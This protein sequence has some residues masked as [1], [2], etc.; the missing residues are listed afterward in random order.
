MSARWTRRIATIGLA[1][2]LLLT[3]AA[4]ARATEAPVDPVP[5]GGLLSDLLDP[6]GGLDLD[7]PGAGPADVVPSGGPATPDTPRT[8]DHRERPDETRATPT[9][10]NSGPA[11]GATSSA[12][13]RPASSQVATVLGRVPR[14]GGPDLPLGNIAGLGDLAP[15]DLLGG[16]LQPD[17]ATSAPADVLPG[18]RTLP[19]P[20]AAGDAAANGLPAGGTAVPVTGTGDR[21]APGDDNDDDAADDDGTGSGRDFTDGRPVAGEDTDFD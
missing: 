10:Q 20:L 8:D 15:A 1:G 9:A 12:P 17:G 2:G 21:P 6:T 5:V 11:P 19:A 4:A 14:S 16:G 3:G 18:A 13:S 7:R